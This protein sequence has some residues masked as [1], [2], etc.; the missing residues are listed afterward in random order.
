MNRPT[1]VV[2][3][4]NET[5]SDLA[6]LADRF[7]DVGAPAQLAPLWFTSVLR[8]GLGLAACGDIQTFATIGREVGRVLLA[9]VALD[10]DVDAAV[11][12]LLAGFLA[13][14]VYP[15]VTEGVRAL[16]AAGYRLVTLSNG[17][18]DVAERLL[19]RAGLRGEF[20]HLLSVEDAGV[21]KPARAPY[22]YAARVCG[23][24]P[25]DMVMV[26]V[27]PWD[28]HGAARAGLRTAWINR[29]GAPY[30]GHV[31]PPTHTVR[32]LPELVNL[33]G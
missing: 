32:V 23:T 5:L 15:D 20:E 4:V 11:D 7:T 2:F 28:L 22:A 18:A 1:V 19:G 10:R 25:A 21:W 12:H 17:A 31:Q 13:L 33:L 6:P 8:E 24:E 16:R 9:G 14:P 27:H 3:D 30:P 29:T 26:A